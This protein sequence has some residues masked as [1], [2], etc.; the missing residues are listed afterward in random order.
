MRLRRVSV[1]SDAADGRKIESKFKLKFKFSCLAN[2]CLNLNFR[3]SSLE[4]S[5]QRVDWH[6]AGDAD[7]TTVLW[8]LQQTT[9]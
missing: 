3:V 4:L 1:S 9:A 2:F 7:E 6:P 8:Y 5:K